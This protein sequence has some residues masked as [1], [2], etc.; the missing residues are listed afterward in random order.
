MYIVLH[1][2][3]NTTHLQ[4]RHTSLFDKIITTLLQHLQWF[5]SLLAYHDVPTTFGCPIHG[6]IDHEPPCDWWSGYLAAAGSVCLAMSRARL[7]L[8]SL[9][10]LMYYF[11]RISRDVSSRPIFVFGT[12]VPAGQCTSIPFEEGIGHCLVRSSCE[13]VFVRF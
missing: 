5:T 9:R 3:T 8:L 7:A 10:I 4:S 2:S 13:V 11:F 1:G 12:C 6:S